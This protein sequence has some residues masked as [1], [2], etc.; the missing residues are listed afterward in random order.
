MESLELTAILQIQ[1]TQII[2]LRL[3]CLEILSISFRPLD[4][5]EGFDKCIHQSWIVKPHMKMYC[6]CKV[7]MSYEV[8]SKLACV[9][10][11]RAVKDK[12]MNWKHGP[13]TLAA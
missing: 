2:L 10:H 4:R 3:Y 9:W 7:L 8:L 13:K 5:K 11:R 1:Q 12:Y 6:L